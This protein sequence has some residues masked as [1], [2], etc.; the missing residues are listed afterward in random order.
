MGV[1]DVLRG[2][3]VYNDAADGGVCTTWGSALDWRDLGW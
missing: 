2:S 1:R 3:R